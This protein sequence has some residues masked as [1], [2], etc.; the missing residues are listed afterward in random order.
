MSKEREMLLEV[1]EDG[2]ILV[3][4][5]G[6]RIRVDVQHLPTTCIWLPTT[7]LEIEEK[8]GEVVVLNLEDKERVTGQWDVEPAAR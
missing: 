6:R 4:L 7:E 1:Q 2:W 3:L 8:R 5:D